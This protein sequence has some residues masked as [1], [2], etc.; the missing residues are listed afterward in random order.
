MLFAVISIRQQP[1]FYQLLDDN[2]MG[3]VSNINGNFI[4]YR[5]QAKDSNFLLFTKE[6]CSINNII[7]L[8]HILLIY[9]ALDFDPFKL[10]LVN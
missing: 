10:A 2:K 6:Q 4:K 8:W 3:Y 5:L 7:D 1:T 9:F